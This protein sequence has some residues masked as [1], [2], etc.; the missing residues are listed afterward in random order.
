MDTNINRWLTRK[1]IERALIHV[2][3]GG[4]GDLVSK[5]PTTQG[6][7][8]SQKGAYSYNPNPWSMAETRGS[9]KLAGLIIKFIFR[10]PV[11][12]K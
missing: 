1:E 5:V 4:W 2:R 7:K 10:D 11:S 12:K 9:L 6:Y 8:K 3:K